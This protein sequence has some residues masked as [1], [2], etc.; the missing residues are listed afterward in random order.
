MHSFGIKNDKFK[1][2]QAKLAISIA[3]AH[4]AS[5]IFKLHRMLLEFNLANL[6]NSLLFLNLV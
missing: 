5:F 6:P 3:L 4:K 2:F 1:T